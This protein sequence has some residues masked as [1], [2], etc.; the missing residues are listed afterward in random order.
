MIRDQKIKEPLGK[1][2]TLIFIIKPNLFSTQNYVMPVCASG[3]LARLNK[4]SPGVVKQ[5]KV[6]D[7][8]GILD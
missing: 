4:K 8:E 2:F 1:I 3:Q 5:K 6:S 7:K